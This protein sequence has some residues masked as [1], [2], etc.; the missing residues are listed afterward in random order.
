MQ[1]V[2][3]VNYYYFA[4]HYT[5]YRIRISDVS[6]CNLKRIVRQI[7]ISFCKYLRY[8]W[9]LNDSSPQLS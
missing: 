1:N 4:T 8:N 7:L 9:P 2:M 3:D 5:V 6:D